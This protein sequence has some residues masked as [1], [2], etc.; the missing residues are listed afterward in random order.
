MMRPDLK[1]TKKSKTNAQYPL[2][3]PYNELINLIGHFYNSSEFSVTIL[4]SM[5]CLSAR[6]SRSTGVDNQCLAIQTH[7][8]PILFQICFELSILCL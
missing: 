5:F 1:S 6:S 7:I 2:E 3:I 4:N 8:I